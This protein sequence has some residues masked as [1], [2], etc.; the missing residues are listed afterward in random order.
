MVWYWQYCK[1]MLGYI[2][3]LQQGRARSGQVNIFGPQPYEGRA[4]STKSG[5]DPGPLRVGQSRPWGQQGQA[6]P[7]DSVPSGM[8]IV[9]I[10]NSVG[11]LVYWCSIR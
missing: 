4:R 5:P 2:S 11:V 1:F 10:V 6:L 3:P 9:V 8:A 7:L